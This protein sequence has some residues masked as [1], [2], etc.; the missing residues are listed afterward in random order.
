[1][2]NRENLDKELEVISTIDDRRIK[3]PK[4]IPVAAC[5]QEANTLY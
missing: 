3:T 5:V 1:M 4:H 2:S